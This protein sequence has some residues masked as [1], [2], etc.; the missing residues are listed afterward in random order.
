[1][2]NYPYRHEV[3]CKFFAKPMSTLKSPDNGTIP[4]H[5]ALFARSS[6]QGQLRLCACILHQGLHNR[7]H[8]SRACVGIF[9]RPDDSLSLQI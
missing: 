2:L 4:R 5:A 7:C 3:A 8:R 6:I 1:V 9:L